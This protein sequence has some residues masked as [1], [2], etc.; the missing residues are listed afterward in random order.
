V[1]PVVFTSQPC[2][3]LSRPCC[4]HTSPSCTWTG[5]LCKSFSH[6]L[7]PCMFLLPTHAFRCDG[8]F[9]KSDFT[10]MC[11]AAVIWFLSS[12]VQSLVLLSC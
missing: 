7:A 8:A 12:L 2:L 10:V 9:C 6:D 11:W 5:N 4:L 3:F 1:S